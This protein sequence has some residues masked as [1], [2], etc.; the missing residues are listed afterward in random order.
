MPIR[1]AVVPDNLVAGLSAEE[2]VASYPLR[3]DDI[4][5]A[6]ATSGERR[7]PGSKWRASIASRTRRVGRRSRIL[8]SSRASARPKPWLERRARSL[9]ARV[10]LEAMDGAGGRA[11]G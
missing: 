1:V 2:I 9:G 6:A 7:A 5:A 3:V 10:E 8:P 11:P 4:R